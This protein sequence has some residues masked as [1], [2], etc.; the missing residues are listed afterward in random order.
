MRP[1]LRRHLHVILIVVPLIL[2]MTWPAL[3]RAFDTDSMWLPTLDWDV[4]ENI[5]NAWHLDLVLQGEADYFYTDMMFYPRGATLAYKMPNLPHMAGLLL[6]QKILPPFNAYS[7]LYLLT[8]FVSALS[9]YVYARWL[10]RDKWLAAVAAVV[11]G[12]SQWV[13]GWAS[14]PSLNMVM[15]LPLS[16][17]C[18]H[19][20]V[21]DGRTKLVA[22]AGCLVGATAWIGLYILVCLAF[23]LGFCGLWLAL[24]RWRRR[25]FWLHS[26]LLLLLAGLI[27]G[28]RLGV[29]L[30][31]SAVFD[32]VV[33]QELGSES[34]VDLLGSIMTYR[35]PVL[36]P[37][38]HAVFD[39]PPVELRSD[40]FNYLHNRMH[41]GYLGWLPLL[42]VGIGLLHRQTRRRMLPWLGLLIVFL[43]LRLGSAPRIND[44]IYDGIWLPKHYLNQLLPEVFSAFYET[45][46]FQ[47]GALLPLAILT[48]LGLGAALR[49]VAPRR[50]RLVIAAVAL[51]IGFEYYYLPLE[52]EIEPTALDYIGWLKQQDDQA[53][54]RLI[55]LP[56]GR[57]WSPKINMLHQTVHNYP[58]VDGFM[59]R[60]PPGARSYVNANPLLAAW[61]DGDA[62]FCPS[63]RQSEHL[64]AL[65]SLIADGLSHV[66]LHHHRPHWQR[67]QAS[68]AMIAP[69]YGDS[70]TTVL[71]LTD[72]RE[73]C[74]MTEAQQG[75]L[76]LYRDFFAQ[77][78]APRYQSLLSLHR[79]E[80]MTDNA[81]RH[82]DSSAWGWRSVNHIWSKDSGQLAIQSSDAAVADLESFAALNDA[83]L[84][85]HN[86]QTTDQRGVSTTNSWLLTHYQSCQRTLE[87]D[88]LIVDYYLRRSIPCALVS[89]EPAVVAQY[90]HGSQL[91][92]A[93]HALDDDSV[94]IF[95]RWSDARSDGE[96]FSIQLFDAQ[97]EKVAQIDAA[98]RREPLASHR[99][100]ISTLAAGEYSAQLILYD[101][102]T[103]KSYGGTLADGS[104]FERA[105]AIA[106]FSLP[107][108]R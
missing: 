75:L 61:L 83:L 30:S 105:V 98:R 97:G 101:F 65:D 92:N 102:E 44:H 28:P 66:A 85:L 68:F 79:S 52:T 24:S 12:C 17:Y 23:T 26:A 69:A 4:W 59:S 34:S 2:L 14:T 33:R 35:H 20:G 64:A 54:I 40:A 103:R 41:R 32:A 106:R 78:I 100:D 50:R 95:L 73:S 29:M 21:V 84:L 48:C 27:S 43:V 82:A 88:A 71:R 63:S 108:T 93:L 45:A 25:E 86:P 62:S 77:Q 37:V 15:T 42:L 58:R 9:A 51:A 36:T 53:S 107:W 60:T 90:D 5:W 74:A 99:I 87:S 38:Y 89:D 72:M 91:R 10:L 7:L 67:F 11:F 8:T 56:M 76:Q 94:A 16:L 6:L 55:H 96:A 81:L 47:L 1:L 80:P 39:L 18:F 19:R 70:R 31:D 3:P 46:Y 49:S 22:V 104:R 57:D 13:L